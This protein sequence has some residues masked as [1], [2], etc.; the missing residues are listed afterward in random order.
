M[1]TTTKLNA[2]EQRLLRTLVK[3][4]R[5]GLA[6]A[7][8]AHLAQGLLDQASQ[9]QAA[10]NT[11][12]RVPGSPYEKSS[13]PLIEARDDISRNQ[14]SGAPTL[15]PN[16]GQALDAARRG[17]WKGVYG[18]D[19]R[20]FPKI[21]PAELRQIQAEYGPDAAAA[22]RREAETAQR[23][24]ASDAINA[25]RVPEAQARAELDA[26]RAAREAGEG[27]DSVS[28][29]AG[30]G[31]TT[32]EVRAARRAAAQ[33]G[34]TLS[35]RSDEDALQLD[36]A[37]NRSRFLREKGQG[38]PAVRQRLS[39][40][41]QARVHVET[42]G[43]FSEVE[44]AD[45]R[46]QIEQRMEALARATGFEEDPDAGR[47]PTLQ[48]QFEKEVF[49]G[50][51]GTPYTRD[52]HGGWRVMPGWKPPAEGKQ[53]PQTPDERTW[54]A[55]NEVRFAG[56]LNARRREAAAAVANFTLREMPS[57][58]ELFEQA[59]EDMRRF[60]RS[61]VAQDDAPAPRGAQRDEQSQTAPTPQAGEAPSAN[62]ERYALSAGERLN[63][64]RDEQGKIIYATSPDGRVA[65][66]RNGEWVDESGRPV[67]SQ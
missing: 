16:A 17:D 26:A 53:E 62:F 56:F 1:P 36:R 41:E 45:L 60:Y 4:R 40:L 27:V 29:G 31:G 59:T 51:D 38:N 49:T 64:D 13:L 66:L 65:W 3:R 20:N 46:G 48:E 2:D 28:G 55:N 25:R 50:E 37:R 6:G 33:A 10:I 67:G 58:D 44:Q 61:F 12:R 18:A 52:H 23:D 35:Q 21:S 8:P 9:E 57:D 43:R 15:A 22:R 24:A 63:A 30:G 39:E 47:K 11:P 42:S 34:R 7:A 5:K 54:I 32:N 14:L 19:G